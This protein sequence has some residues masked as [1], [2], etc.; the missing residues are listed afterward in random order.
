MRANESP[1]RCKCKECMDVDG[2][3]REFDLPDIAGTRG[4]IG[5]ISVA[6]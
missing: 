1:R 4:K 2:L 5:A 3:L 6:Q